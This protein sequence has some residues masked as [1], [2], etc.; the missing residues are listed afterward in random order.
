MMLLRRPPSS[1]SSSFFPATAP[2]FPHRS[3]FSTLTTS[4]CT[5]TPNIANSNSSLS[6]SSP[7]P[8]FVLGAAFFLA[9]SCT[10]AKPNV[11]AITERLYESVSMKLRR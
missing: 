3:S 6:S 2:S 4:P 5:H 7:P 11:A 1:S 8:S 10:I 9:T